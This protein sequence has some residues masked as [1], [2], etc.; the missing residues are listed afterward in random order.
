MRETDTDREGPEVRR[1]VLRARARGG[2]GAG[3]RP[4]RALPARR[5]LRP[6]RDR[7]G[8]RGRRAAGRRMG[9]VLDAAA[10]L[11]VAP[12]RGRRPAGGRAR[13]RG[14]R[15]AGRRRGAER[16]RSGSP[17]TSPASRACGS[18][19][20]CEERLG[21]PVTVENDVSL[22][23]VGEQWRGIAEG[24]DDFAF[25]SVGTGLGCG[26]VLRGEL[27]RG[28]HGAAGEVDY[29]LGGEPE[30][31]NDP[32]AVGVSAYA[33]RLVE[34]GRLTTALAPPYDVARDLRG[35]A[36]GR[37]AG[38]G[39]RGRGGAADR[40]ATSSRSRR[41]STSRSSSSAV[42]SARTPTCC[43]SR[44]AACSPSAAP[45]R[46]GSRSPV[47]ATPRCSP[48]RSRSVCARRWTMCS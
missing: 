10:E 6:A 21:L 3:A 36:G 7:A 12:A 4:R 13:R 33:E 20:R 42:A 16:R 14:R 27:H 43:S 32:A 48:A 15:R 28:H 29:A 41:S 44:S 34:E 22:A 45:T 18:A 8:A 23:A 11:R 1:D 35:G 39:R 40:R 19:R 30:R 31:E 37:R 26:L 25:L 2:A 5:G 9:R 24:V 17:R 47:S 38:A 46:R